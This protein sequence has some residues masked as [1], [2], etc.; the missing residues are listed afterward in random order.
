MN[1]EQRIRRDARR[2]T[3]DREAS[4]L[5]ACLVKH[6]FDPDLDAGYLGKVCGAS[7]EVRDR[8]AAV[9]G[10]LKGY[11]TELRMIEA[12]RLAGETDLSNAELAE[13]LGYGTVRSFYRAFGECHRLTPGQM[14]KQARAERAAAPD[15]AAAAA[16]AVEGLG[17]EQGADVTPEGVRE[18]PR[19][20]E[21]LTPRARGGRRSR[22]PRAPASDRGTRVRA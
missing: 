19:R 4:A 12:E 1:L 9:V 8:L 11:V 18:A 10:R 6:L 21:R 16:A 15:P 14:R 13:R 22:S 5:L 7:R 2:L 17:A 3:G 20:P